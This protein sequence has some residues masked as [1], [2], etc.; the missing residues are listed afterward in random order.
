MI[1]I[2]FF[3][4]LVSTIPVLSAL[5]ATVFLS[6]YSELDYQFCQIIVNTYYVYLNTPYLEKFNVA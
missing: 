4:V 6:T 2:A 5:N 3:N 1:P